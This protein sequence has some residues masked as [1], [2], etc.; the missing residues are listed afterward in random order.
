M[1]NPTSGENN[2]EK[3][4]DNPEYYINRELSWVR[5]NARILEEARDEWH[6]LLERVKFIAICGSN[7]DEFFMTRIARL[8]KK[9]N[10]GSEETAMDGMTVLEQIEATRKEMLPLIEKHAACWK[11]ELLPALAKEEIY[12]KNYANLDSLHKEKLNEFFKANILPTLSIH[13]ELDKS[14]I[15]NLH[16]CLG[17]CGF[18]NNR[19]YCIVELPLEKFGRLIAVPKSTHIS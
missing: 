4:L 14:T 16:V 19:S 11:N 6:P 2:L 1:N 3:K 13:K 8:I 12:I 7:L 18:S 17:V 5:F 10:K 9:I 15:E